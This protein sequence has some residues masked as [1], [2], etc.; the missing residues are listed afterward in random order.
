MDNK[1]NQEVVSFLVEK[2]NKKE[3]DFIGD[4][5]G[6]SKMIYVEINNCG[7]IISRNVVSDLLGDKNLEN[8]LVEW[9]RYKR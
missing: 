2:Y 8:E 1:S 9:I 4:Y 3:K 5:C 7:K 6:R